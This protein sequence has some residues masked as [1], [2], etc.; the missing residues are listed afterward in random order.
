MRLL[1]YLLIGLGTL[2]LGGFAAWI[3]WLLL[4]AEAIPL[5]LRIGIVVVAL[6]FGILLLALWLEK[7]REGDEG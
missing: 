5:L 6:G 3:G 1:S 7:R 4:T 2:I